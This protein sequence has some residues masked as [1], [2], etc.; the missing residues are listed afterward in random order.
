[1]SEAPLIFVPW[2]RARI[3]DLFAELDMRSKP[4]SSIRLPCPPQLRSKIPILLRC[5]AHALEFQVAPNVPRGRWPAAP[6]GRFPFHH[7]AH[8]SEA[9]VHRSESPLRCYSRLRGEKHFES[10]RAQSD[11]SRLEVS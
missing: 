3:D 5:A 1:M 8:A 4:E 6:S 7:R 11:K 2:A 10:L 9:V